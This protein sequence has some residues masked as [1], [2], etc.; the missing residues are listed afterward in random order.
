MLIPDVCIWG[1]VGVA[2]VSGDYCL[3]VGEHLSPP[4]TWM[5]A[6][7]F[8]RERYIDSFTKLMLSELHCSSVFGSTPRWAHKGRPSV[9]RDVMSTTMH[10]FS[11]T[12]SKIDMIDEPVSHGF[13][14][15]TP[16][17]FCSG[18]YSPILFE[19]IDGTLVFRVFQFDKQKLQPPVLHEERA[20][21]AD[22][23]IR[24]NFPYFTKERHLKGLPSLGKNQRNTIWVTCI[25]IVWTTI[26]EHV[27]R[28]QKLQALWLKC[29]EIQLKWQWKTPI[30]VR[31]RLQRQRISNLLQSIEIKNVLYFGR[32]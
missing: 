29:Q 28:I 3:L 15:Q 32:N 12:M 20:F 27:E 22:H 2:E 13:W 8:R 10:H 5:P 16:K 21:W 7:T 9:H 30:V 18:I 17:L 25:L 19:N 23:F 24:L 26:T 1:A 11:R 6:S 4:V 14:L 31:G